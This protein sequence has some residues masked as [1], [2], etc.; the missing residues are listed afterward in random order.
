MIAID[1][2]ANYLSLY[3]CKSYIYNACTTPSSPAPCKGGRANYKASHRNDDGASLTVLR[4]PPTTCPFPVFV[5][6]VAGA[7]GAAAV[8]HQ[9]AAAD[10]PAVVRAEDVF[11]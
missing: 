5:H 11:A 7:D 9:H 10:E 2:D 4:M 1:P 3:V 8:A 6:P